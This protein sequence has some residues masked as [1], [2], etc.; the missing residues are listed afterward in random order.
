[1]TSSR[2]R[3]L[4]VGGYGVFGGR[5]AKLLADDA[6]CSLLIAGRSL[7]TAQDFCD[8][9]TGVAAYEAVRFDRNGDLAVQL[10][11]LKPDIIVDAS[12]P[13]QDYGDAPYKLV[14]ASIAA[15]VNYLDLA[16]GSGFVDGV[17]QFD[18]AAKAR[19]VFVLS[20]V[21]SF[22]VLTSAA[23]SEL[24]SGLAAFDRIEAGVAP[25]PYA[26]VGEN[27]IRA[28]AS[29]A[30]KP[31]TLMRD[32]KP[33]VAYGLT[34]TRRVTIA[35]P[36]RLPLRST[37]FSLVDVPDL[38]VLPKYFPGLQ[39]IWM[40]AG[41]VPEIWHRG[42]ILFANGVRLR[43]LPALTPLAPLFHWVINHIRWGE[44][45]GGLFVS[46]AGRTAMGESV[47]RSWHMIADGDAGPLIPSMAAVA[48]IRKCLDSRSPESGARAAANA[49]T[50]D[51]YAQTFGGRAIA[52]GIREENAMTRASPLYKRVLGTAFETLPPQIQ[53]MHTVLSEHTA[54]GRASVERGRNIISRAIGF[55]FGFP[56]ASSD[57][58][59]TVHFKVTG[60]AETWTRTFGRQSFSSVQSEGV[61]R[62]DKL[63]EERF[64]PFS[65]ALAVVTTPDKLSLIVRRW[66]FLGVPLPRALAPVGDAHETVEDGRFRFH[67]AI[68]LPVIGLLVRYRGYLVPRADDKG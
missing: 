37:L 6:R 1:M 4:I 35:P 11:A 18:N 23:V 64:G 53:D 55:V 30:G 39:S 65:F 16:D 50:L 58:P 24:A 26:G 52:F 51:D 48:L 62:A 43:L 10:A 49:L 45:R 9:M 31:V 57:V 20:G 33:A 22:P 27:V 68:S 3:I 40:G 15:G 61:G 38:R 54:E 8:G 47:T 56:D 5:L 34:E 17:A 67:V 36:G 44:H 66:T 42:L 29:Y 32:G 12:G 2:M 63:I 60:G 28:I 19:G 13:F 46:V 59:V 25:S 41:P 7:Q 21:S 14:S